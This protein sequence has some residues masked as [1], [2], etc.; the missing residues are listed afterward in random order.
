MPVLFMREL[1]RFVRICSPLILVFTC[2]NIVHGQNV[3]VSDSPRVSVDANDM[4]LRD[5]LALIEQQ[6]PYKF[7][8]NTDL[9]AKQKHI[10]LNVENKPLDE[11]FHVVLKGTNIT[12]SVI[13]NQ[14]ILNELPPPPQITISGY[15]KDSISGENLP[16]AIIYLPAKE[17]GTYTNNYGFFSLTQNRTDS[18]EILIS[19][20]GFNKVS[21]KVNAQQNSS[22]NFYLSNNNVELNS[23]LI[24][25]KKA[26]DNIKKHHSGKMDVSMERVKAIPS[27][28]GN[29][30]IVNSI[31][32]LP[33][34]MAGLDGRPGYFIR[35]GNTDQNLV[36]LDEATLYN[37][38]HLLGLVSVFNSS[39]IKSAY[40]LKAGFP[41]SF[42]DHLSSV[43][44]VTMKDGNDKQFG[45]DIQLGTISSGL[46]LSG[47]LIA[48]KASLFVAARRSTIDML[49]KP[50]EVSDYYSNYNFYDV[51]AKL[52]F[53]ISPKDRL[54]V[55]YYQGRDYSSYSTD[56]TSQN[57]IGYQ[58]K[59]GN[60][61]LTLR[62]NHLYSQKL[63]SNTSVTYN[64]YFHQVKARQQQFYAELY[65]GI[66]DV[67]FKTD[68]NF[69]P[70][71]NHKISAGVN[72]LFQTLYPASATDKSTDAESET[73]IDPAQ[74]PEKF[75]NRIAAYFSDE[76][77]I[78]PKMSAYVGARI[79]FFNNK[80]AQYIEFEPRLSLMYLLNPTSSVKI[81]YTHMHQYL[82]LVQSFNASFPAQ[83]WIGSSKL[84]KPQNSQEASVG[85]FKNFKDN[86]FQSSLEV[87]YKNMGNQLLF[88]G[89]LDPAINSDMENTLIFGKGQSYG[90]E[91][92]FGKNTGK[93]TGWLAYTL[94]YSNQKFD[95]LNL[96]KQFPFAND[97]RHSLYLSLSYALNKHW[98]VSS[99][100]LL[101]SG[102][103]FTLFKNIS[104]NRWQYDNP[105]YYY[106]SK[107][108]NS[109]NGNNTIPNVSS[110]Q[111][112]QNNYRLAPYNRLDLSISYR[113]TG[114]ILNRVI[115]TEWVFSVYNVYARANTFFAYCS[116]DPV[117][118][119][120]IAVEVSFIPIIPSISYNVRF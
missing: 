87:Y 74:I 4:P 32:M 92:F 94:S 44:D 53:E 97:R 96:G 24:T 73:T 119:R 109:G 89:G 91:L 7:A 115:E 39:A 80:E 93:L 69:Y 84:V 47:P 5:V 90:A 77:T 37:P 114:N 95:S 21:R 75:S 16:G 10:N 19:Y 45:G 42:G 86:M 55:S 59:Y 88:R 71:P 76:I 111:I 102:S 40:L 26:D 79:P 106:S 64:K 29:G 72:Y 43:L 60:Q 34:V 8:Y 120:P 48:D 25:D 33:G 105:L 101:T 103:A 31:Q 67:E 62:W 23:V 11:L 51:N 38:N 117:T 70:N 6:I 9:I 3:F 107:G 66:S 1:S 83:I 18:I 104:P 20:M 36:Q 27:I 65:S 56:T 46:T 58:V 52:N 99:N 54:Y 57:E 22:V 15:I 63:F 49:L 35:G 28:N 78:G 85:F 68:F 14:I 30:D 50:L 112:A 110:T 82:H 17:T 13:D 113:K 100:F 81:S 12:Y 116:I 61:A 98:Q 2:L 108:S 118:K 41:A